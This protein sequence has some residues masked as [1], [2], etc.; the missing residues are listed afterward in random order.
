MYLA[1]QGCKS[2]GDLFGNTAC[3]SAGLS[4]TSYSY[5]AA[6]PVCTNPINGQVYPLIPTQCSPYIFFESDDIFNYQT[7]ECIT[8]SGTNSL[9]NRDNLMI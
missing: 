2:Y 9:R 7:V 1:S 8:A 3:G 6:S 5:V 4:F